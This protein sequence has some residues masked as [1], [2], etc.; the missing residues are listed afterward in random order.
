M[1]FMFHTAL[2]AVGNILRLHYKSMKSD[3]SFSQGSLTTLFRWGE[4]VFH[5]CVKCSSC[6]QQC[7]NIN[8]NQTSFSSVV[9]TNDH[10]LVFYETYTMYKPNVS[11]AW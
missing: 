7:K 6:L 5:V 1:N 10:C 8:Q 4:H 11:N 2:D 3:V 9:I